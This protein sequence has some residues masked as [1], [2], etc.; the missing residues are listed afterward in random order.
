MEQL[1]RAGSL[2]DLLGR[3]VTVG[4]MMSVAAAS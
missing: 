4:D 2:S 3:Y 1:R